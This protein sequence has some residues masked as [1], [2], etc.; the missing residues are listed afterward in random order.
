MKTLVSSAVAKTQTFKNLAASRFRFSFPA[1]SVVAA[2][3]RGKQ[4]G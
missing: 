4:H 2:G 1:R 3:L